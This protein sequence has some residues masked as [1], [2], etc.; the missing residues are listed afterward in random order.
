MPVLAQHSTPSAHFDR[1]KSYL[2]ARVATT[3]KPKC[4]QVALSHRCETG[5]EVLHSHTWKAKEPEALADEVAET[6]AE[7]LDI[8]NSNVETFQMPQSYGIVAY[9]ANDHVIG[10]RD[11]M[12][13]ADP[14][15]QMVEGIGMTEG[16][17]QLGVLMQS[18]RLTEAFSRTSVDATQ[19]IL[20][21]AFQEID[22]LRAENQELR[23]YAVDHMRA[24]EEI[25][26][27]KWERDLKLRETEEKTELARTAMSYVKQLIPPILEKATDGKIPAVASDG[28]LGLLQSLKPE[29]VLSMA[30]SADLTPEQKQQLVE[31]LTPEQYEALER[32]AGKNT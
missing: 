30:Q 31:A 21:Q 23:R 7:L 2:L 14:R 11:F 5:D 8:A 22:R 27:R 20:Q 29:Q 13:M 9:G 4:V 15:K 10:R 32:A 12:L 1:I 17:T 28:L 6:A 18:M 25:I 16:P 3:A 24:T 19:F 26:N